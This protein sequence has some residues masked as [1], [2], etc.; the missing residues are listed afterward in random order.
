L[1]RFQ[2]ESVQAAAVREAKE[3]IGVDIKESDIETLSFIQRFN[4]KRE[5]FDIF[6][7]ASKWNGTISNMEPDKCRHSSPTF[8]IPFL[9]DLS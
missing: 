6:C 1:K 5:Y 4:G 9:L 3:E 2:G 7:Q 8:L